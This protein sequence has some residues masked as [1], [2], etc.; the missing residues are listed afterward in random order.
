MKTFNLY[1]LGR[2]GWIH[3]TAGKFASLPDAVGYYKETFGDFDIKYRGLMAM[4][5]SGL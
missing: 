2:Y 4:K 5:V 3:I 1:K